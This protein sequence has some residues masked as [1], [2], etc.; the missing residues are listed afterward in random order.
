MTRLI[1]LSKKK[2]KQ[3]NDPDVRLVAA[4]KRARFDYQIEESVEAGVVLL[5]SEVKSIRGGK[6]GLIDAYAVIEEDGAW[7]VNSHVAEYPWANIQNHAPRRKRKLLL[8]AGELHRLGVKLRERGYTLVPLRLYFRGA[9]VKVEIGL[10]RG[11]K[12]YDKRETIKKRDQ[13]RDLEKQI[14]S[15]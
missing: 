1:R 11:K 3:P 13:D 14:R 5:G 7:L 2:P 9:H 4:N 10:A 6:A 15:H 12:T 8:H